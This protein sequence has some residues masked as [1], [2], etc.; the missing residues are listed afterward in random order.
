M[1]EF[2]G[3]Y[4]GFTYNGVHSSELG[5]VRTSNGSR[6][7]ENL[8]P[9]MQDKTVQIPGG[10][11]TYYFGSFYTQKPL[12]IPFAFDGLTEDKL[13]QL[14]AHFGDKK[15][16]DLIFDERPY[17]AYGAK[18]T[19]TA[20]LKYIPFN[21]GK[22]RERI[23]K[24]E[25]SITFTCYN[26][27]AICKKKYLSDYTGCANLSEWQ[28]ASGL[29]EQGENDILLNGQ[30]KLYNP[31]VKES[32][33]V[34][35]LSTEGAKG[36][37]ISLGADRGMLLDWSESGDLIPQYFIIDSKN[38]LITGANMLKETGNPD[39]EGKIVANDVIYNEYMTEGDFF[40]IPLGESALQ[41][42]KYIENGDVF[43]ETIPQDTDATISYN[44]Y[45]F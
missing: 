37:E 11:G 13:E 5:I 27:Y 43:D 8:L 35:T 20:T 9:T 42:K 45:Y 29:R 12:T 17:K 2:K 40:K 33:F 10:D 19:G 36:Y 15:I 4:L 1:K 38:N 21:E 26:P 24:G 14:R 22:E 3:D 41:I 23:Y 30:I 31:G 34:L 18:V 16:H 44:Y 6:F 39:S 25:G 28:A 7:E 32:D